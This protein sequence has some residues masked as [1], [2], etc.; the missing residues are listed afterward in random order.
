MHF[1]WQYRCIFAWWL[2]GPRTASSLFMEKW[3]QLSGYETSFHICS[4]QI[5]CS[6][7]STTPIA[8]MGDTELPILYEYKIS[9]LN[10]SSL[11]VLRIQIDSDEHYECYRSLCLYKRSV[12]GLRFPSNSK[13]NKNLLHPIK[14]IGFIFYYEI[15]IVYIWRRMYNGWPLLLWRI[16]IR[17]SCYSIVI[18]ILFFLLMGV[19]LCVLC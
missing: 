6:R 1:V 4:G 19:L 3:R 11:T 5:K 2:N 17:R 10:T 12:Y 16:I 13:I 14:L 8:H 15:R 9:I 7:Y 18:V